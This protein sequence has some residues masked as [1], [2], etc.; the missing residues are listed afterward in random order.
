MNL[1]AFILQ[2]RKVYC[3]MLAE[4]KERACCCPALISAWLEGG[5]AISLPSSRLVL[6]DVV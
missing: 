3:I 4:M 1:A 2:S 5:E 6:F